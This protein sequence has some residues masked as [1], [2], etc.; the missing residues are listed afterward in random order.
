MGQLMKCDAV[1]ETPF[2]R[3][4]G[5]NGFGLNDSGAVARR[6]RQ[7]ARG[8]RARRAARVRRRLH[9]ARVRHPDQARPAP[10]RARGLRRDVRR[11]GAAPDRV[12]RARLDRRALD[13]RRPGRQLRPR[14]DDVVRARRSA[15]RSAASTGPAPRPR[16]T[17]PATWTAPS[18]PASGPRPRCW[19]AD[20][21]RSSAAGRAQPARPASAPAAGAAAERE[22]WDT[23]VFAMVAGAGLPGVRLR[24]PQRPGVRRHLHQP[25]GRLDAVAG[26]EWR[27]DGTL[28]RSWTRAR[29]GPARP[30]H[31]VQ[32]ANADRRG[33]LVLLE[34]STARGAD[35]AT[36]TGRFRTWARLPDL[37]D[38]EG[39]PIPNYATWGPR[40]ALFVTDYGQAVIWKIAADGPRTRGPGSRRPA[41]QGAAS[42]APP[43]SST[44]PDQRDLLIT[45]QTVA[46]GSALPTNGAPLPAADHGDGHGPARCRRCGPR[47]PA[48]CPTASASAAARAG[49]TSPTP[50]SPTS[51]WCSTPTGEELERFPATPGSG[52][53]GSPVPFDTPSN[54]TF[55]GTAVAGRQ[56]VASPAT[57]DHHAILDVY[58]GERGRAAV[59]PPPGVLAMTDESAAG[60]MSA[61][62]RIPNVVAW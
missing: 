22:R 34:K 35:P 4:A 24:P 15:A 41:L 43:A 20:E 40:G 3:E 6:L 32:V 29:P 58:V 61:G 7:L 19:S 5:L 38:V 37:P 48:T 28:L 46:D 8:R 12:H 25:A 52:E 30:D 10:G 26:R 17:G 51:W 56:P 16:R 14:H 50:A 60:P 2:W 42:S 57:T 39:T 13:R 44:G 18:A 62:V 54:A 11:A 9:L 47:C 33:R 49:S 27:A 1:Y 59:P 53:N 45:Q 55:L 31:G 36:R 23:R 21:A